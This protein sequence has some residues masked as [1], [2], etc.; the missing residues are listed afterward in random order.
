MQNKIKLIVSDIDGTLLDDHKQLPKVFPKLLKELEKRNI[1][2]VAASGR[3]FQS[4]QAKIK[5]DTDNLYIIS[6]NGALLEHD[7]KIVYINK[8]SKD[9]VQT[10]MNAFRQG[11]ETTIMATSSKTSY[12]ELHPSHK[13]KML[14]EQFVAYKLVDDITKIK[15]DIVKISMYSEKHSDENYKIKEVQDLMNNY[16]LVKSDER[17]IDI[18]KADSNKGNALEV[19]LKKLN[20]PK[21]NTIGFGDYPNDTHMLEVVGKSYTMENAHP[22]VKL[23]ADEIIGT[24]N[25]DSVTNKIIELLDLELK[26]L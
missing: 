18:M 21:E 23:V 6:N 4:I 2:F 25:D 24:N 14:S 7:N 11:K 5:E 20:I 26:D 16:H 8:L 1:I 15:D 22:D 12:I 3:S 17:F 9:S 10:I 13:E 19:L